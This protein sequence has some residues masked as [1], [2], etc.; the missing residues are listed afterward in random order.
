V[1]AAQRAMELDPY[2]AHC[3]CSL[4]HAL[5][6]AG[7]AGEGQRHLDKAVEINPNHAWIRMLRGICYNYRGQY[8]LAMAEIN[9]SLRRDPFP[10]DWYWDV[11]GMVLTA[12]GKY[13]RALAMY[14]RAAETP[15]W[16]YY[17]MAV[18]HVEL[19]QLDEA[20]QAIAK[21][22]ALYA[23]A[24]VTDFMRGE[25]HEKA[26]TRE[27]FRAALIKAGLPE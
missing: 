9:E 2:D 18:C 23:D 7:R 16:G 27:R 4:G 20:R 1:A 5:V 26:E 17:H 12:S 14:G 6:F 22:Q 21:A 11:V 8:E 13:D 10:P 3:N 24:S 25:P 19:G 15:H